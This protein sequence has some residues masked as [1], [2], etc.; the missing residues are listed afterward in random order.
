MCSDTVSQNEIP[1][2]HVQPV[3]NYMSVCH[4]Y[5][6][7]LIFQVIYN[8]CSA[9]RLSFIMHNYS[10]FIEHFITISSL[11]SLTVNFYRFHLSSTQKSDNSHS[12]GVNFKHT[13]NYTWT[14]LHLTLW[15]KMLRK[16][17][18]LEKRKRNCLCSDITPS[19]AVLTLLYC[20]LVVYR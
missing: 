4:N 15:E 8:V 11:P 19:L 13:V 2:K 18:H 16:P 3:K 12:Y 9:S 6:V 5:T 7:H 10:F 14:Y 20:S 17:V 1:G